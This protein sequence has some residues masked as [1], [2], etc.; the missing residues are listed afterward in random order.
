MKRNVCFDPQVTNEARLAPRSYF[1]P[2]P[3]GE[4]AE[5]HP[6]EENPRY[7]LLNGIWD[8][9]Y[10]DTLFD[11]PGNIE[12]TEFKD[13][14]KVPSCWQ[15][16]GYGQY[17]YTNV[18]YPIAC[19]FP[20]IPADTPVGIYRRS[21]FFEKDASLPETYIV[22]DGVCSMYELYINGKR[23]GMSKGSR[24]TA[25]FDISPFLSDG[26]NTVAVKVYTY[27][28]A[29]YLE[30][31]DCFRYNGIFRDVY[32]LRR[33]E[34][35]L[36]DLFIRADMTGKL[37]ISYDCDGDV[38]P[39]FSLFAPD[40][41]E[42]PL[43]NVENPLLWTAETPYLYRLGIKCGDEY[44]SR[45]FGFRT[46]SVNDSVLCING[47]AVKLK[48]VNRHDTHPEKGYAVNYDDMRRDL[49][50]MKKNNI[51]CVRTSHY[52]NQPCFPELCDEMGIYLVEECDIETHGTELAS[53]GADPSHLI[54]GNPL[55]KTAFVDRAKMMLERDK[56]SPS[57]IMWSLGNESFFGENHVAMSEWIKSRDNTRLVHYE[58]TMTVITRYYKEN[59]HIDDSVDIV[60]IM[61]PKLSVLREAGIN[62]DGDKRPYFMCEYS[63]A[64]GMGPG[65]L[66]DYWKLIYEYPRL[67]GGC[68]WEWADHAVEKNGEYLYG[69]DFGDFPNDGIFCVDGLNYPDRTPHIGLYSLR[70][71]I[72]PA[73][74]S[75]E[76]GV[77]KIIN[78]L[79][80]V[81]LGSLYTLSCSYKCGKRTV[82]LMTDMEI[83]VPAHGEIS[84]MLK[85][86]PEKA[87]ER[88]FLGVELRL[89]NKCE[90]GD[91]GDVF[92]WEQF[93]LPVA[94]ESK[95]APVEKKAVLTENGR[96]ITASAGKYEIK[97]DC[98]TG[99]I[100]GFAFD[101]KEYLASPS[102]FTVWR[103]PTDNDIY[104]KRRWLSEYI[105]HAKF[106]VYSVSSAENTVEFKGSFTSPARIP[107]YYM[108]VVYTFTD[109]GMGVKISARRP[110]N[111]LLEQIPRFALML[112]LKPGFEKLEYFAKGCLACY[113]DMQNQSE[114]G[115]FNS[116]VTDEYEPYIRPQECGNH[117][118]AEYCELS[119]K[120]EKLRVSGKSFEFSA[121][122]YSPEMMTEVSHRQELVPSE[123][124]FLLVNYKVGGLGTNSCGP[125]PEP[126]YVFNDMQFDFEF[127]I[128]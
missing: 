26:E 50:L 77:L 99:S 107:I 72:Q 76:N 33:P 32:L 125:K 31:Q 73:R 24:L 105:S 128:S 101:G 43:G 64:M 94:V 59:T 82:K 122:H 8:F 124:T 106:N 110:E 115:I 37:D 63:H 34:E 39:V 123:N 84:V 108:T 91:K 2:A 6:K 28:D 80:F 127:K 57:I 60:S 98:A 71:A 49:V 7:I 104:S 19:D 10:F 54:A 86:L 25:E 85:G 30:D 42:I 12:E 3:D 70:K 29:T 119:G 47:T 81:N 14:I 109:G 36:R 78:T 21:F 61:Y 52:P 67:C 103:A 113:A 55:W 62:A 22:F 44:I 69:G 75:F 5:K 11:V 118:G 87:M 58:G 38:T 41:S 90:Y 51:N 16:F 56:N 79:D 68:V 83:S 116:T 120:N 27:S 53:E 111:S 114:Y 9:S 100:T 95:E 4:T 121:L 96:F 23:A 15:C 40:G 88:C 66:E 48:G 13:T 97:I 126:E 20:D 45:R 1:I 18:N 93:E 46:V 89:K 117:L 65:G 112:T 102:V 17:Q 92:A 35:R 74:F